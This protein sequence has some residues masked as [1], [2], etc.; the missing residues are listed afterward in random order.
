MLTAHDVYRAWLAAYAAYTETCHQAGI[1]VPLPGTWEDLTAIQKQMYAH[2]AE[3]LNDRLRLWAEVE[4][5]I[6][7]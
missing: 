5:V 3:G 2:M 4:K 7:T 6:V 1:A